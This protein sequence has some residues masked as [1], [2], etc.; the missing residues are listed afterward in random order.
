MINRKHAFVQ[1]LD[2]VWVNINHKLKMKMT[3]T[4]ELK[5]MFMV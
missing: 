4:S 5:V 3:Q 1:A 2:T